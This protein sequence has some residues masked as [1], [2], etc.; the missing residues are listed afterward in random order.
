MNPTIDVARRRAWPPSRREAT[1]AA[2]I[3]AVNLWVIA[4]VTVVAPPGLI[5][6]FGHL[7]GTDF[8]H[9]Y[10]TGIAVRTERAEILYD[11]QALH[12]LQVAAVPESDPFF[13][14]SVYPPQS[15][16][17]FAPFGQWSYGAA[18]LM[19]IF[20]TATVYG[21]VMT[22]ASRGLHLSR[23]LLIACLVGFPAVL[24]ADPAW[25]VDRVAV[26]G[27]W[28]RRRRAYCRPVFRRG[29]CVRV[30]GP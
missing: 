22:I 9:F 27:L 11:H 29:A 5:D 12:Q 16:V 8:V 20:F 1:I 14:V 10:A 30:I 26:G 21:T 18:A 2:S 4:A 15:A 24:A 28:V 23:A 17:F 19:W 25:P 7:K 6:L 3:L 13:Y